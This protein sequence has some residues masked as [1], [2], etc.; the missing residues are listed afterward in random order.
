MKDELA[1]IIGELMYLRDNEKD[2]FVRSAYIKK[3]EAIDELL[4]LTPNEVSVL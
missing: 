4:K 3:I 2:Y 1:R